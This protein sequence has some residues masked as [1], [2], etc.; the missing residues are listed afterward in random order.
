MKIKTFKGALIFGMV[1]GIGIAGLV[2]PDLKSIAITLFGNVINIENPSIS[3]I[4]YLLI[5]SFLSISCL[6]AYIYADKNMYSKN[7]IINI[8][9]LGNNEYWENN[10]TNVICINVCDFEKSNSKDSFI[11]K[12]VSEVKKDIS[13]YIASGFSFSS[14]API[15]L[16]S[17]IGKQFSKIKI[18]DYY[19]YI[20]NKSTM[21]TLNNQ[22]IFPKLKLTKCNVNSIKD[23]GLVTIGTT[24]EIQPHQLKQFNEC[25]QYN[26]YIA[27]PKENAIIS[28]KQ[29]FNYCHKII[30]EIYEISAKEKIKRIYLVF[31]SQSSLPFE[32]AKQINERIAKEVVVCH[33]D[34]NSD[35]PYKWGII[36]T[37]KNAGKYIELGDEIDE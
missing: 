1:T 27:N 20:N 21:M 7:R 8:W 12:K 36:I 4:W 32:I 5:G 9:G 25:L 33:Y 16:V 23:Y 17:I 37:G 22:I 28:K 24:V 34:A 6:L 10:N 2:I 30:K 13:K 14:M 29:L 11:N 31:S 18:N 26:N 15:P 19:E 35:K 3:P